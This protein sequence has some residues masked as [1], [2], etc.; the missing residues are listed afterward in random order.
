MYILQTLVLIKKTAWLVLEHL[1]GEKDITKAPFNEDTDGRSWLWRKAVTYYTR[2]GKT[3]LWALSVLG[4]RQLKCK[5]R[6]KKE[7]AVTAAGLT[8]DQIIVS[9]NPVCK[10]RKERWWPLP[11][12]SFLLPTSHRG[13]AGWAAQ[14]VTA[15]SRKGNQQV[16]SQKQVQELRTRDFYRN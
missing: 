5:W 9:I 14:P 1:L 6:G 7:V 15:S 3:K 10:A 11:P 12:S 16:G 13:A 4:W 8:S 2:S